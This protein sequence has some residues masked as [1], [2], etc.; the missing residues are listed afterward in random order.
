MRWSREPSRPVLI[1]LAAG[2]ATIGVIAEWQGF[3]WT[4]TRSWVPDLLAGWALA[5]LG[6]AAGASG[7]P[8]GLAALLFVGGLAWYV[9]DFHATAPHWIGSLATGLSWAFLA[10]LLQLALAYPSGRPRSWGM[11]AVVVAAWLLAATQWIDWNDDTSL[12]LAMGGFAVVGI[13]RAPRAAREGVFGLGGLILLVLWALVVPRLGLNIRP[14]AFDAGVALVGAGLYAGV[15]SGAAL[16]ERTIELDE[17]T[18]SLQSA[19]AEVLGDPELEVGYASEG[20][21]FVDDLGRA[22]RSV[23]GRD[24][25]ELAD[26]SGVVGLIV[27]GPHLLRSPRDH[28]AVTGVVALAGTRA[29]MRNVLRRRADDISRSTLR[30]I[31]AG[32]DERLRLSARLDAGVRPQ[33]DQAAALLAQARTA[34]VNPELV[35]AI[36]HAGAQLR[37]AQ[38]DVAAFASGLGVPALVRTLP[39]AIGGLVDGLPFDVELR[40]SDLECA[41]ELAGTIWFVCS[42]GVSNVL[43]HAAAS[44]I[45]IEIAADGRRITVLVEDDGRG[46]ADASGSGL[47]GLRDRATALGGSLRV[48]ARPGGGTRLVASLPQ[49]VTTA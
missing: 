44:K 3:A 15:R 22:V 36:D 28:E 6:V 17:S 48:E 35:A 13:A 49:A 42:E 30:L 47:A 14:I 10:P 9:G 46:G 32:D 25:T 24:A 38:S 40:V 23:P 27:H 19:L 18:G 12:A 39:S 43:K 7:R 45:L 31:R 21:E 11:W 37:R 33:L 41:S 16:V 20:G 26:A 1:A 8:R 4:E 2:A 29:R 5:G 34:S